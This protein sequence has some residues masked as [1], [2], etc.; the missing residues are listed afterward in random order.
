LKT[1]LSTEKSSNFLHS[2]RPDSEIK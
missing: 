1:S 2:L